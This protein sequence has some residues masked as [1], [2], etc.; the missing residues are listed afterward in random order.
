MLRERRDYPHDEI[1]GDLRFLA[2]APS[3]AVGGAPE[4]FRTTADRPT[5]STSQE[6]ESQGSSP[7]TVATDCG[8]V[9]FSESEPGEALNALDSKAFGIRSSDSPRRVQGHKNVL[10]RGGCVDLILKYTQMYGSIDRSM[11]GTRGTWSA[12]TETRAI[13]LLSTNREAVRPTGRLRF[14]V[15]SSDGTTNTRS[16]LVSTGGAV[17]VRNGLIERPRVNTSSRQ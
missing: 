2:A 3:A 5:T 14:R 16:S 1:V 8:T 17:N 13:E 4:P 9:V 15:R 6:S 11:T 7:K 12:T 10:S